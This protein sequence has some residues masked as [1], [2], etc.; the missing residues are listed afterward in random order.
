ML[1]RGEALSALAEQKKD[2]ER[3]D[4]GYDDRYQDLLWFVEDELIPSL[5]E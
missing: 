3:D 1:T 4:T 2:W 5:P